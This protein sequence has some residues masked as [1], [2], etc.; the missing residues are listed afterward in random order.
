VHVPLDPGPGVQA[1]GERLGEAQDDVHGRDRATLP[2]D[3]A[4]HAGER[5]RQHEAAA[6]ELAEV[7]RQQRADV[8]VAKRRRHLAVD[9]AHHLL[10]RDA[11]GGHG[12]HEGAGARADVDVELVDG[13]VDRQ[14]VE[15]AQGADLVDAA[16]EAAA[17][18]DERGLRARRAALGGAG[19]AALLA[20]LE[21]D[22]LAHAG[23]QVTRR[24]G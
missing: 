5:E 17:A 2:G 9:D 10:G 22:D 18:E 11:V 16:G 1:A 6:R 15:G 24:L 23:I 8:D 19:A 7:G 12:G 21:V 14:Q 4:D 13:A 20:G 3:V